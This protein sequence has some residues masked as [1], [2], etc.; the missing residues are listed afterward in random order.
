MIIREKNPPQRVDFPSPTIQPGLGA[1]DLTHQQNPE[2][3]QKLP[4]RTTVFRR[5]TTELLGL[6]TLAP[7][8]KRHTKTWQKSG[9]IIFWEKIFE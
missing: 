2:D 7:F 9:G 5:G 3:L 6:A 8:Q 1:L 4:Q